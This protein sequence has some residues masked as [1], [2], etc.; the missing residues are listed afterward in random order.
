MGYFP[1]IEVAIKLD[2]FE[3]LIKISSNLTEV[4]VEGFYRFRFEVND[5]ASLILVR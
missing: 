5:N 3:A 4:D 2:S 1:I